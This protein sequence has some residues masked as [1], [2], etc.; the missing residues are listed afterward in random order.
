MVSD[1]DIT[2]NATVLGKVS[3]TYFDG[4]IDEVQLYN[5]VPT[6]AQI[7]QW[8]NEGSAVRFGPEEGLP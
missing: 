3:A 4:L 2:A 8:Y 7:K 6:T 1:A 5:Y